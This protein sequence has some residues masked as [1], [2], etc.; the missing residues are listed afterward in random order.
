MRINSIKLKNIRSFLDQEINFNKGTTLLSGDIGSGKSTILL[1][2]CFALFGMSKG[3][4]SGSALLRNGENE[5]LVK[6]NFTIDNNDIIIERKLKKGSSISQLPGKI[7][8]NKKEELKS[9]IELKQ[10]ILELLNYPKTYLT[11]SKDIIFY[12]TVFTPQEEMK[13][14]L[15]GDKELRL[16]TL[17]KVFGID[18]YSKIIENALTF[19][20]ILKERKEELKG[21]IQDLD[22]K[23]LELDELIERNKSFKKEL[24]P[25]ENE[26]KS[27]FSEIKML[28]NSIKLVEG[29]LKII[30]ETKNSIEV[31]KT[32]ILNKELM[33]K[34]LLNDSNS[35]KLKI[36]ELERDLSSLEKINEEYLKK[37]IVNEKSLLNNLVNKKSEVIENIG[38]V[39]S[40]L[41]S[42]EEIIRNIKLIDNCPLCLQKVSHTHKTS[43]FDQQFKIIE[44]NKLELAILVENLSKISLEINNKEM[45]IQKLQSKLSE[46]ELL[47][48][49]SINL[50]E[51]H[52][53]LNLIN[54]QIKDLE[55]E[56]KDLNSKDLF[57]IKKLESYKNIEDEFIELKS[58]LDDSKKIEKEL[59]IKEQGVKSSMDNTQLFI[60][61]IEEE[62]KIKKQSKQKL[63]EI[64]K[65]ITFFSNSLP[66]ITSLIE[67]TSMLKLNQEF[68]AF[69]QRFFYL[70]INTENI[71]VKLDLQFTPLISQN[72]HDI[73]YINL[74]GGEKTAIALAYRLALNKVLNTIYSTIKTNNLIILDEPTD[75]FS[76]EQLD[77]L[78][79]VLKELNT[80]QT[81]IVSHESKIESFVE[82]VIRL[83]KT[84]HIS[85]VH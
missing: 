70:L 80:E 52:E 59:L 8:I 18:K 63:S 31:L 13:S 16:E 28:E 51:S 79:D 2:I 17:R 38:K 73:E 37:I 20:R 84:G 46:L 10:T 82:N 29:K 47:K 4:L 26:L 6:L 50:K 69:F 83:E 71:S 58:K 66:H 22:R 33:I 14:I 61:K 32:N 81:I 42:S 77:K 41:K 76:E 11:K 21:F 67:K 39:K 57:L 60:K 30:N 3:F 74:S 25:L 34:R 35:L 56:I 7:T 45:E 68:N 44:K 43:I 53:R 23:E 85:K 48:L 9:P 1:A 55:N 78:R 64:L 36:K 12:Y 75:G 15:L 5:G 65:L 49:K 62:I 72:G 40:N 54:I 24:D 19:S 27:I